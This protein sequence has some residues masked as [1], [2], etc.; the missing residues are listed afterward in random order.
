MKKKYL[1]YAGIVSAVL[2]V[3][4]FIGILS[5]GSFTIF[6]AAAIN[7]LPDHAA[8][9]LVVITG[10]TN[11]PAG[12]RLSLDLLARSP[13]SGELAKVG[14]ADAFI[15]RGGGMTNTWSGALDTTGILP[16]EYQVNAY[17][18]DENA[19]RS[20]LLATSRLRLIN[21]STDRT[22]FTPMLVNHTLGFI[23]ID[24]PGTIARGEKI[25]VSG[26]TNLAENSRFLYTISQQSNTTIFTV[27]QK[28]GKPDLK[29]RFTRSGL[30]TVVPGE[31][32]VSR[33][34][35]ALDS[36]EFPPDHY[37]VLVIPSN[38]SRDGP[39]GEG[40][41]GTASLVILDAGSDRLTVVEPDTGPCHSIMIDTFPDLITPRNYTVTGTTSLQPGTELLF[42]VLPTEF[43]V[44]VNRE[45]ISSGTMTG[46][47]GTV[48]VIR[49]TG[50]TNTWSVDLDLSKFPPEKYLVNISNDRVDLRT[51][52]TLYGDRYCSRKFTL[53][54]GVS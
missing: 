32:G 6:P 29:E 22:R 33:W 41:F 10:T 53:T 35:F 34:S 46:A 47:R 2:L 15:A 11:Y 30:I 12:S 52:E 19:S 44:N 42:T 45:G 49:G 4:L 20:N 31:N 13:A 14:A 40:P 50:N 8:G 54:G 48:V 39:G 17:G 28:T 18:M 24:R 51:Y 5:T 37:E 16:G 26:T 27:D 23:R 21:T 9:D 43:D 38:T 3:V 25:L 1:Q 36:T 7:P